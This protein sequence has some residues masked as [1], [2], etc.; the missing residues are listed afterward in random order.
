MKKL[1]F[2]L[3]VALT[4]LMTSC[5]VEEYTVYDPSGAPYP[6]TAPYPYY[7][8][9]Y[10]YPHYSTPYYRGSF[11]HRT[12]PPPRPHPQPQPPHRPGYT[13]HLQP[14][15][16]QPHNPN[17]GN[18]A[19]KPQVTPRPSTPNPPKPTTYEHRSSVPSHSAPPSIGTQYKTK[20]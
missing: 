1:F 10:S 19:P 13:P 15:H 14:P 9:Y 8:N 11:Y 6:T 18:R 4:F 5:F 20:R 2:S 17:N 16:P 7:Y 12:P 3:I